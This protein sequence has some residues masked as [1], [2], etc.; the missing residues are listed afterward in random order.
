MPKINIRNYMDINSVEFE[1]TIQKMVQY[2]SIDTGIDPHIIMQKSSSYLSKAY[3]KSLWLNEPF[4]RAD[5]K[6]VIYLDDLPLHIFDFDK[7]TFG[8][9]IDLEHL[10]ENYFD[11]IH[12]IIASIYLSSNKEKFKER[13]YEKYALVNIDER[14]EYI[15]E[16]IYVNDVY[17]NIEKYLSFRENFFNHFSN[18]FVTNEDIDIDELN[19]EELKIYKEELKIQEK[20]KKNVWSD[21]IEICSNG[22]VTK[23]DEVLNTNLFLV[24]SK[25]TKAKNQS[26]N[27]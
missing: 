16:N 19:E 13:E 4:V 23:Y 1:T 8:H 11:N 17:F 7:I 27:K 22:D 12:Y 18:I 14:A 2:I 25:L 5:T 15:L 26:T 3:K 6:D 20:N 9:F 24:F 21:I 10:I